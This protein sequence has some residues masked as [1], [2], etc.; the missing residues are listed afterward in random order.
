MEGTPK[1]KK[2]QE[3]RVSDGIADLL[4]S[5]GHA[6]LAKG[7]SRADVKEAKKSKESSEKKEDVRIEKK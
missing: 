1:F 5:R 2:G 6:K 4:V 7:K 3:V